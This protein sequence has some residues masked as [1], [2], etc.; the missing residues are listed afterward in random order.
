MAKILLI[1][2]YEFYPPK[3]GGALRCFYIM[4]EMARYHEVT[5]LTVQPL[6]DFSKQ[7]ESAFPSNV[8]VASNAHEDYYKSLFNILPSR[9]ANLL[10]SKM[11]YRSLFRRGSL[12]LLKSYEV[13]KSLLKENNFDFVCYENLECFATFHKQIKRISP[14]TRHIYDAHNV[15]SELWK[16]QAESTKQPELLKYAAGTL[17]AEKRLYLDVQMCFCCSEKDRSKLMEFNDNRLHSVVIPNGV[18]CSSRPYDANPHKSAIKNILFCG[19]LDYGPNME[20]IMWFY[21]KIFPLVKTQFPQINFTVVGKMHRDG[22][23]KTLREDESVHFIGTV[24]DVT[25]YYRQ[26]SVLVVPLLKGSGTRLKILEAMSMGNPVVSTSIGAEGLQLVH[27]KDLLI[28]DTET[29][30]SE[31]IIELLRHPAKFDE[32][33][34]QART[35]V[36]QQ[37]DWEKVGKKINQALKGIS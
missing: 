31:A 6:S 28:A 1:I 7:N 5:L 30:F 36:E 34:V 24:D 9:A 13:L 10:N 22:P 35:L 12:Y 25:D 11:I 4:R 8:K 27:G 17:K 16:Q 33:R 18:D 14:S 23:F 15:D 29:E 32:M 21:E 19:T 2:P 26:S 3:F 37:Y 20:G